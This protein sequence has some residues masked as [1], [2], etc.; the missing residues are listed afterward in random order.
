MIKVLFV[1]TGNICRSPMAEFLFKNMVAEKGLSDQFFI[2]SAATSNEEYGNPVHHGTRRILSRLGISTDGKTAVQ[3]K[4]SDY[5]SYDYI[6][7][8]DDYNIRGIQ[9]IIRNNDPEHKVHKLLEYAGL[10][11]D[12]DD[13]WYTGDFETAYNDINM[14]CEAFLKQL[15]AKDA[16]SE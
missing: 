5:D 1:C 4:Y 13:P 7:G 15:F 8:M 12:I 16:F 2:A 11:R 9:R 10:H 6:L 3:M 14:G